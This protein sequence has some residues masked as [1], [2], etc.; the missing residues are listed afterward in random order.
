MLTLRARATAAGGTYS[1]M[2]AR[3]DALPTL[4]KRELSTKGL[5][6]DLAARLK[7]SL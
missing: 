1:A 7:A 3:R 6:K 5:K 2:R 4:T